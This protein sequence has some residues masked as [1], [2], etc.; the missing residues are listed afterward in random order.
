MAP[1]EFP[2]RDAIDAME[3]VGSLDSYGLSMR[4]SREGLICGPSSG[5]NLKGLYQYLEKRKVAGTLKDLAGPNGDINCV[6]LCCDL[7]YQYIDE[8]FDRLD[9]S[10]FSEIKNKVSRLRFEF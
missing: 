10:W 5:F 6:F 1:V 9:S 4:L 8:Y 7:P 3:E 2:W